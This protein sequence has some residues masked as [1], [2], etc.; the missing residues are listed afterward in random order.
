MPLLFRRGNSP[1]I[2]SEM[3]VDGS[4][5]EWLPLWRMGVCGA[6]WALK[7]VWKGAEVGSE[8]KFVVWLLAFIMAVR[9]EVGVMSYDE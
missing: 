3:E 7:P 5:E 2:G 1:T 9:L 4:G 8:E 6:R